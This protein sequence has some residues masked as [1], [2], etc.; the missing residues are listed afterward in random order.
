MLQDSIKENDPM[1]VGRFGLGFKSVL[2]MTGEKSRRCEYL[3]N[4]VLFI[5]KLIPNHGIYLTIKLV[6][7][8]LNM[9]VAKYL[10]INAKNLNLC[11]QIESPIK[12][13]LSQINRS[14]R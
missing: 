4:T 9:L 13:N 7:V 5:N 2:H 1:K 14:S 3:L 10:K 6:L 8:A 12:Y 11:K